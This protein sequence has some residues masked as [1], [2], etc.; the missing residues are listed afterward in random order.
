MDFVSGQKQ[1]KILKK[2]VNSNFILN[3]NPT[4][5][6]IRQRSD[7]GANICLLAKIQ[8]FYEKTITLICS[9]TSVQTH[10][11]MHVLAG[12]FI[13][14]SCFYGANRFATLCYQERL[15]S[16]KTICFMIVYFYNS[17]FGNFLLQQHF[18]PTKSLFCYRLFP[19]ICY[20][21]FCVCNCFSLSLFCDSLFPDSLFHRTLF[22]PQLWFKSLFYK[23]LFCVILFHDFNG[24]H[25]CFFG[26]ILYWWHLVP[27][28]VRFTTA[29]SA[30]VSAW[31]FVSQQLVL[32]TAIVSTTNGSIKKCF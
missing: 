13:L 16:S 22:F 32:V 31:Q 8:K 7:R 9:K 17:M 24:I 21:T 26:K 4:Y 18:A 20:K 29:C 6:I 10:R 25:N 28:S 2:L 30:I 12:Q 15:F 14:W 23:T 3:P 27:L 5:N 19:T 11:T 1:K